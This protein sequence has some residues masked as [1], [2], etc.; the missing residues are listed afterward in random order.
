[1]HQPAQ[2]RDGVNDAGSHD[3]RCIFYFFIFLYSML[4]VRGYMY[5]LYVHMPASRLSLGNFSLEISE[6][7]Q[8]KE[9]K[10]FRLN[11]NTLNKEPL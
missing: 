8:K 5:Y 11:L 3:V 6:I 10:K 2:E 1:M 4:G 7:S 9:K